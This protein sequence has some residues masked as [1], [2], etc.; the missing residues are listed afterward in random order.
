ML[1]IRTWLFA[2]VFTLFIPT[3]GAA[4]LAKIETPEVRIVYIEGAETFLVPY[5]AR[6]FLNSLQ[7]QR[8]LFDFTPSEKPTILLVDFQDYGNAW[9]TSV[10]RDNVQVQIAPLTSLFETLPANERLTMIA[11]HEL[12]H[13]ATMDQATGSDKFFRRLF[14]GKVNPVAEQPES[15]LYFFL[16]SP[17]VAVPSW[18]QEGVAVFVE[19]WMGAGIGRAQSGYD[20]M[21]FR[22]MAKDGARFYDP[23]GLVAEGTKIDFQTEVNSY[24]YGTRF[25]TWVANQYSPE[26]LIEW[27]SRRPG[28]RAYYT[29]QFQQVFGRSL[30]S[31]WADWI[32]SEQKFQAENLAVI[33]KH[34]VTPSTDLSSRALGSVSR[35]Y[36]D[37][38][39]GTIYAALNYPGVVAHVGAISTKS[40]TDDVRHLVD[41]KGPRIYLVASL[42]WDEADT[43]YYTT[44]NVAYRDLVKL[45][46]PTG[47]TEVLQKDLRV[48]DLV[49]NRAD[50][51][52]WG[53]RHLYGIASIVRMAPP[54]R[55]WTRVVSLPYG[56]VVYDLDIS[57][58]GTRAA[59]SFGEVGGRQSVRVFNLDALQKGETTPIAEFDFGGMTVPNGFVFSP[60]GRFLYGSSYM[61]GVSNIFRYEIATKSLE[62][63]TN[64]ETGFF[65]PIPLGGD[66]LIVFRYTGA[67]FVPARLTAQPI[68]DVSAIS[69]LG[70]RT[71]AKHPVLKTW[72][73]GSPDKVPFD[74][75]PQVQGVY[76]LGGGLERE[77]FYPILQGY[78]DTAAVGV[79]LD[80]SDPLRLNHASL[81]VSFSPMG[82]ITQKERLHLRADYERYDWKAHAAWNSSDFYDLFGPTR[83]SRRG[84]S[85]GASHRS[86]LI[87]DEPKQLN[88]TIEGRVAGELD[89][90][91]QYQNVPVKVDQLM[92]INAELSY[93]FLRS[94]LGHVD[95]E[96]G[97]TA[98]LSY[99]S[100]YVNSSYFTRIHGTYDVGTALP[101]G[102]SSLW[103]RSAAGFSPQDADEPFANFFFGGFGNNYVDHEEEKRYRRY[104]S[105]PGA[106][107]NEIGGRNFVRSLVEWNLP[108]LRFSRAG[109]PGAYLSWMRP[110]L[111]AGGLVTNLD[112][113][114]L[115]RKAA[116]VGGQVDFRF[117]VLSRLDLTVSAGAGVTFERGEPQRH[118]AMVSLRVLR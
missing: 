83:V 105:F 46:I 106:E 75:M 58:D 9:A 84:Y 18:Y 7:F 89:Q 71:I 90:L 86:S 114:S 16:T 80:L 17:R 94:S 113:A 54:Y 61:T 30:E 31:A 79:R 37:A 41:I 112:R 92:S 104:Y 82:A 96:K 53:I 87:F 24:L 78:K 56:T 10:P 76:H 109:T 115:Q 98:S 13:V 44:D 20:E 117:T 19:T 97:Q 69:F 99:E 62:A 22:A 25:M 33:R 50:K 28:S 5:A 88:L 108:P 59:A 49:M 52:L 107:L 85:V 93:T 81:A 2:L 47:R 48:G 51:S 40:K 74:S 26:K 111:F 64:A 65:R 12:T 23:L 14:L 34:S 55:E 3:S 8:R 42:A 4:Q 36:Y 66:E 72:E 43:L 29:R 11:N 68:Q 45:D 77:S 103:L 102:H 116:T 91:P 39:S 6:A 73:A 70:E 95:D 21:V 100:D 15:I 38:R 35:A 67:G 60:D 118:E 1:P 63:V 101:T 57:A 27:I 32:V 110:A